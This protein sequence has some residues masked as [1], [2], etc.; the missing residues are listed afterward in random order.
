MCLCLMLAC[1]VI[2]ICLLGIQMWDTIIMLLSYLLQKFL[3]QT[4]QTIIK[5][6]NESSKKKEE[7]WNLKCET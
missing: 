1:C 6:A 7:N 4:V 2:Q 3:F 5:T